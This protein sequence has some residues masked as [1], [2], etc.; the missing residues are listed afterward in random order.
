MLPEHHHIDDRRW[1]QQQLMRLPFRL[2][3]KAS[4]GY[5]KAWLE[6]HDAEPQERFKV[7][8]GRFEANTRMRNYVAS[9]L[10]R[11]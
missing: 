2:R 1:I 3:Q 6:A 8:R 10:A 9:V 4:E 5:S 7:E 11:K